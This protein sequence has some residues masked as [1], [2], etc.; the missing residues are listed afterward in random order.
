MMNRRIL[1]AVCFLGI[2]HFFI[3][4]SASA[5]IVIQRNLNIEDGLVYSQVLSIYQDQ[6]GYLWIGTSNGLSRWDG[7]QFKNYVSTNRISFDNIKMMT[8]TNKGNLFVATGS[9]ILISKNGEFTKPANYPSS[10]QTSINQLIKSKEGIIY[11]AA[12]DSGLWQ[13][14]NYQFTKIPILTNHK[15][16]CVTS[17]AI[18]KDGTLIIGTTSN[19]LFAYKNNQIHTVNINGKPFIEEINF[20]YQDDDRSMYIASNKNG[21]YRI[22]GESVFHFN[23]AD[24][25]PDLKV[26]YIYKTSA[27]QLY[28]AT[29]KGLALI[30][31]EKIID[32]I[33]TDKGLSNNFVWCINEDKQGNI[34]FGTDGGGIDIY[35]PGIFKTYN[36]ST[37]LPNNTVW[38]ILETSDSKFYFSTDAGIA[39]LKDSKLFISPKLKEL[40]KAMIISSMEST[41]KDLFFGTNE[42]GVYVYKNGNLNN[43]NTS[44]G[45]T[46]NSVWSII[47]D[48]DGRIYFGTYDGG[49]CVY[50]NGQVI[51]TIDTKDGLNNNYIVS[52]YKL[53]DES[54]YFGLD[55]GGVCEIKNGKLNKENTIL[56]GITVWTMY[57]NKS[58]EMYFGTDK[59]GLICISENKTDTINTNAGLSNNT[60]LGILEDDTGKLYLA[61]DNG[62]N[63]VDF[64]NDKP[65]IRII[66]NEDGLASNECNQGAY[67]KDSKGMFWIGTIRGVTCYNPQNDEPSHQPP[68]THI[69]NVKLFNKEIY[70][71]SLNSSYQFNYDENYLNFNFI[72]IDLKAPHKVTYAYRLRG[73][74][75]D[76]VTTNNPNVQYANLDDNDYTFEVKSCNE[77]G[78][79]SE[80]V[81]FRFSILPPFWETWWFR[82]FVIICIGGLFGTLIYL[83][84][85]H[86]LIIER[87]RTKI[88]ADLHDDIGSGLSEINILSAVAETKM[89]NK[90]KNEIGSELNHIS[91]IAGKMIDNMSDIVWMVN[92]KKD[93][94]TDLVSRLKDSYNDVLD[95]K[96]IRF[97]SENTSLLNKIKLDMEKRQ[98]IFLIFKEAINNA[99]KYSDCQNLNLKIAMERKN[100]QI[101]LQDDGCGFDKIN[102]VNGNGLNN[103]KMRAEKIKGKLIIGSNVEAGTTINLLVKI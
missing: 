94:M 77:W 85:R 42:K 4:I 67:L 100:L 90:I 96:N 36:E 59:N 23:Q 13:Y 57:Q 10:L 17:L 25:L 41:E 69:T 6:K 84:F 99:I 40:S 62:L 75:Q 88:A 95:A 76:W 30:Q 102:N 71:D 60:I 72:G 53:K 55:A 7:N 54:I 31:N 63:I 3:F 50:K 101:I 87:V 47:E 35:R 38:N 98:F 11:I 21:L 1:Y 86:L 33:N 49:I 12:E 52:A 91:K 97:D 22:A 16:Y 74:K 14:E 64:I 56:P 8:E 81:T 43:I 79:W 65:V 26:N 48:Q 15:K 103:M 37:G 39:E 80:P 45:L 44:N 32:V 2:I 82:L 61:T 66:T 73:I 20:V 89:Q 19:G 46:S 28:I 24:G 92:P 9:G 70:I 93:S 51:D 29:N 18:T 34:Y 83:R 5:Q 78:V 58:G 27:G 68:L